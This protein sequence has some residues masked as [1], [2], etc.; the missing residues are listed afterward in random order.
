VIIAEDEARRNGVL[1]EN[2]PERL[3]RRPQW[4]NW[5]YAERD[6][7][8]TKVPFIPG[9]NRGASSTDLMTWRSFEEAVEA[10]ETERY[11][12]IGFVFC[13]ADPFVGI[14]L[15]GCRDPETGK[16]AQWAQKIIDSVADK[17]VEVSPSG[18]GVH[19]I[20]RGT[21]RGGR[22]KGSLEVYGQ[23]H[24]FTFTGVVL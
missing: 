8:P 15:D 9:T 11:D 18:R 1:V 10:Y 2:I 24:F 3:T 19:V 20:T 23:D 14:D 5:R 17:Y 6:D 4:V 7:K 12:G 16:I 21:L 22:K 13:S